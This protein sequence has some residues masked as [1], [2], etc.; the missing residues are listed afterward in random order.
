MEA[1]QAMFY[2][3]L[4]KCGGTQGSTCVDFLNTADGVDVI[5]SIRRLASMILADGTAVPES[6]RSDVANELRQLGALE[7]QASWYQV[8]L[9]R[10][11]AR[12]QTA[13]QELVDGIKKDP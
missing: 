13:T 12:M 8:P 11:L 7:H 3:Y 9:A 5:V 1:N 2:T 10:L 6:F 4:A